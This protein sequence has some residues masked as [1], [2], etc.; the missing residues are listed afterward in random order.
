MP[1]RVSGSCVK[2]S[3]EEIK[4]I[5]NHFST[6]IK[7]KQAPK[8]HDVEEVMKKYPKMFSKR[9]WVTIKAYVYNCYRDR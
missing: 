2:W 8:K 1:W 9:N 3:D 7:N 6:F 5:K 4:I